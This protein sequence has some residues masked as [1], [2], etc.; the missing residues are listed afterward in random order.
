MI[1]KFTLQGIFFFI[2]F[3]VLGTIIRWKMAMPLFPSLNSEYLIHAHSH[4]AVLGWTNVA[5]IAL[6]LFFTFSK[7]ALQRKTIKIYFWAL[8]IVNAGIAPSFTAQGYGPVSIAV[9]T[10]SVVLSF[11]FLIIYFR[12]Q[13]EEEKDLPHHLFFTT[14]IILYVLSAVGLVMVA[15]SMAAKIGGENLFNAGVYFYLHSQ[16]NGWMIFILLG[17]VYGYLHRQGKLFSKKTIT[18]QWALLTI[19]FFPSYIPQIAYIGLPLWLIAAS[20]IGTVLNLVAIVLFLLTTL[21][22]MLSVIDTKALRFTYLYTMLA[23]LAKALLEVGG[24]TPWLTEMVH[25]NRQVVIGYLH[26]T[27]LAFISVYLIFAI[28]QYLFTEQRNGGQNAIF[29]VPTTFLMVF[30]LFFDGLLQ[31]LGIYGNAVRINIILGI[32][33]LLITIGGL[34]FF[35]QALRAKFTQS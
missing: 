2:I 25:T 26:L 7:E 9:S 22:T 19:S 35:L 16:Y 33:S 20:I 29:F 28:Q 30:I 31:W 34:L 3:A 6:V 24:A 14:G 1:R 18:W 13:S 4:L 32:I 17:T 11:W 10:L 8:L 23:F 5:F 12:S 27:L 15:L 21:R